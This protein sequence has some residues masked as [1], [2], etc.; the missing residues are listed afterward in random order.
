M[1][2]AIIIITFTTFH[3]FRQHNDQI[4][5]VFKKHLQEMNRVVCHW[6]L[7]CNEVNVWK[8][9]LISHIPG[10][11]NV[12]S[13]SILI[14]RRLYAS[15]MTSINVV[16]SVYRCIKYNSVVVIWVDVPKSRRKTTE[17]LQSDTAILSTFHSFIT[18][19][20]PRV[21]NQE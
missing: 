6:S 9:C 19:R 7:R 16:A 11:A 2:A 4:N 18:I 12:S 10:I 15:D 20:I 13:R 21:R 14:R 5:V 17:S 3:Q 8:C 1:F